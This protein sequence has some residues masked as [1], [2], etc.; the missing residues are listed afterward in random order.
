M[1]N[2]PFPK[3]QLQCFWGH[4]H[5][6]VKPNSFKLSGLIERKLKKNFK[7]SIHKFSS[8]ITTPGDFAFFVKTPSY[9]CIL[10]LISQPKIKI[11]TK[12]GVMY[13]RKLMKVEDQSQGTKSANDILAFNMHSINYLDFLFHKNACG[14]TSCNTNVS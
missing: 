7:I 3:W 8:K 14:K 11:A 5:Q 9:N 6:Y 2:S 4:K 12:Q 10:R 13:S 1:Q